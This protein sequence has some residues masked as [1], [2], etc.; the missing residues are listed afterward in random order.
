M[1]QACKHRHGE[2]NTSCD[3]WKRNGTSHRNS[4]VEWCRFGFP[5]NHRKAIHTKHL[6]HSNS[7]RLV[8]LYFSDASLI[9]FWRHYRLFM[10]YSTCYSTSFFFLLLCLDKNLYWKQAPILYDWFRSCMWMGGTKCSIGFNS[11]KQILCRTGKFW[12]S[13]W[14]CGLRRRSAAARLLRLWVGFPTGAWMSFCYKCCVLSGRGLCV[15]LIIRTEKSYR[16]W[17]VVVWD[18]ETSWIRR[19]WPTGGCRAKNRQTGKF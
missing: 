18:L 16:L 12:G 14:R 9:F 15:W 17:C 19:S 1:R 6:E 13:Q 11:W 5:R 2:V 8:I 7:T 4:S 3:E 10:T